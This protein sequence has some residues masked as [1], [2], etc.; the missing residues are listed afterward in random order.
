MSCKRCARFFAA[1]NPLSHIDHPREM[2]R[3][4]TP[5]WF[6]STMGTGIL[7]LSLPQVPGAGPTLHAIGEGLWLFNIG[8]FLLYTVLYTSRWI[9]FWDEATFSFLPASLPPTDL[10]ASYSGFRRI[11][12]NF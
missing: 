9:L 6:A 5:N 3:Q 12:M 8:L 1:L 4:F 7:A 2:I 11:S 10:Q